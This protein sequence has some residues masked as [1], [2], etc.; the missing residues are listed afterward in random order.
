MFAGATFFNQPIGSWN[1]SN[2]TD[3]NSMFEDATSF[4]QPIGSW[5]TSSVT[6]MSFM[7]DGA[8]S[9]NQPTSS[10]DTSNVNDM[11]LMFS[12]AT[13]FN[14]NIGSWDISNVADM[15]CNAVAARNTLINAP[16]NWTI[17]G[18]TLDCTPIITNVTSS[19]TN[20]TYEVGATISI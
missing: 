13:S 16:N 19:A 7:F 10:W 4:N 8:I 14:Q 3:M 20:G 11:Y 9:F 12:D 1:T 5:D 17:N 18:D 6:N 2:V 15:S